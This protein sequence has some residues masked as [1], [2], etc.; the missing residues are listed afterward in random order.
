MSKNDKTTQP[1]A[2]EIA[3]ELIPNPN[4]EFPVNVE[5]YCRIKRLDPLSTKVFKKAMSN[6]ARYKKHY[7]KEWDDKYTEFYGRTV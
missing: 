5:V 4:D 6:E 3:V 1:K 7:I 2:P